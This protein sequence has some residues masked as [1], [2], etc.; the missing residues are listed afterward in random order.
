M[1]RF[2]RPILIWGVL[3]LVVVLAM[4]YNIVIRSSPVADPV[5]GVEDRPF[6]Q[7]PLGRLVLVRAGNHLGAFK[8]VR[9]SSRGAFMNGAKYEYWY[10]GD[11]SMNLTKSSVLHGTGFVYDDAYMLQD[12]RRQLSLKVGDL[13][14]EWSHRH[15]IFAH[16]SYTEAPLPTQKVKVAATPWDTVAEIDLNDPQLRWIGTGG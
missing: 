12:P 2:F 9:S 5:Y 3:P 14:V 4:G 11:G 6:I 16:P 13:W 15:K 10:Q 7:I 1:S 8:I